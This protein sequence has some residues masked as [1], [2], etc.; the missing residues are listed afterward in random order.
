MKKN[1]T[2]KEFEK[3]QRD[4]H[5]DEPF[6]E[7]LDQVHDRFETR[8]KA[9]IAA[10]DRARQGLADE[11]ISVTLYDWIQKYLSLTY[12]YEVI[13]DVILENKQGSIQIDYITKTVKFIE[14]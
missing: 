10:R 7:R 8:V 4:F 13:E 11:E 3:F 1:M 6:K 9:A 12:R 14:D 5:L 2:I